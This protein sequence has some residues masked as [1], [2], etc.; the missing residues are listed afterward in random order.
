M[1]LPR[2]LFKNL[3]MVSDSDSKNGSKTEEDEER[4]NQIGVEVP[5]EPAKFDWAEYHGFVTRKE[6]VEI[7]A[8]NEETEEAC[9]DSDLFKWTI[10]S[11]VDPKPMLLVFT[12]KNTVSILHNFISWRRRNCGNTRTENLLP[13]QGNNSEVPSETYERIDQSSQ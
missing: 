12:A 4:Q 3:K 7:D 1:Q 8:F 11:I 5:R 10:N 13:V 9:K 6:D 2:S